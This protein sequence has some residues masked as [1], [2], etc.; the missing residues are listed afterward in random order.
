MKALIMSGGTKPSKE[1][2]LKEAAESSYVIGVDKGIEYLYEYNIEPNIVLGDFDSVDI[3]VLNKITHSYKQL[4]KFPP[5]KDFTDTQA[6]INKCLELNVEEIVIL[7]AT[8][9]RLDHTL[10]NIGLLYQCLERGKKAVIKDEKNTI[11]MTNN[12]IKLDGFNTGYFSLMA[13]AG[14]VENVNIRGAKYPLYDYR[15]APWD[16]ITISNEFCGE[17]V[18]ITFN[19]GTLL[20]FY[21]MD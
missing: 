14:V 18:N 2:A 16:N 20:I 19:S 5:E 9:T 21:S 1:L 7:A 4:V 3:G 15:L 13:F 10:A 12:D 6:A 8:G 11:F 17:T